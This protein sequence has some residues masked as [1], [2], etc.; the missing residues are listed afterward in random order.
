[1]ESKIGKSTKNLITLKEGKIKECYDIVGNIGVGSFGEV[2]KVMDKVT[3]EVRAM[4]IIQKKV[5]SSEEQEKKFVNEI[6]ILKQVSSPHIVRIFEYFEDI[7]SFYIII[8]FIEG[9][10]LFEYIESVEDLPDDFF[11]QVMISLLK[12]VSY[13][14]SLNIVHRDIKPENLMIIEE[15]CNLQLKLID[16]GTSLKFKS[17]KLIGLVGTPYFIAPEV[18]TGTYDFSCDVWSIGVIAFVLVAGYLPFDGETTEDIIAAVKDG[19][20]D[21]EHEEWSEVDSEKREFVQALLQKDPLKRL[22]VAEA[23]QHKA[24]TTSK[25]VSFSD[26][27]KQNIIKSS[28]KNLLF[29]WIKQ[30]IIHFH[31]L[32]SKNEEL[33]Q[34]FDG[35]DKDGN[36]VLIKEE[37]KVLIEDV[38]GAAYSDLLFEHLYKEIDADFDGTIKYNEFLGL[39]SRDDEMKNKQFLRKAFDKLDFNKDGYL[40]CDELMLACFEDKKECAATMEKMDLN[41]DS[42]IDFEEFCKFVESFINK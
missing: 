23:L 35:Y 17:E 10:N 19:D 32:S 29:D 30:Y 13:L 16:F 38:Y 33:A 24:L 5:L 26:K 31:S 28:A 20:L 12:A 22:T 2:F 3:K 11:D 15:N 6:E 8:E 36:G 41:R 37:L 7:S 39:I 34:I 4:K 18:I 9:K 21:F 25:K 42:K 14:H 1:M 40:S 27:F